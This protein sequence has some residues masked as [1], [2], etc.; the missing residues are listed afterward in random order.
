MGEIDIILLGETRR[1]ATAYSP[2][3]VLDSLFFI[4]SLGGWKEFQMSSLHPLST[5]H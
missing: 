5:L 3:A 4:L 2:K 1:E